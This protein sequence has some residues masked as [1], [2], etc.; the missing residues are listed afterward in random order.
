MRLNRGTLILLLVSLVI[1]VV[2]GLLGSQP[3]ETAVTPTPTGAGAGA[4]F[5]AIADTENQNT[6]NRFE[7]TNNETGEHTILTKGEDGIWTIAEASFPQELDTDQLKAVGSMSVMA[8][9]EAFQQ[10]SVDG[11]LADYGLDNP[12]YTLVLTDADGA[13]YTLQIGLQS[14]ITQRFFVLVNADPGT[15]YVLPR[16]LVS[17]LTSLVAQPPYV[18]SPTPTVTPTRTPN[19]VSEVDQT[20]TATVEIGLFIDSLTATA[21][22]QIT[23][24]PAAEI[25]AEATVEATAE[26]MMEATAEATAAP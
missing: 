4:L 3:P 6:I 11:S 9:L 2:V 24:T 26:A 8:S 7:V 19:P 20:A 10:F 17:G 23:P 12:A 16:D 22:A 25:T 18:A 1:I 15:V 14:T 13:T 5:P 21:E